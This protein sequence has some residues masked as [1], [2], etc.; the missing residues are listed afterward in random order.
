MALGRHQSA[1]HEAGDDADRAPQLNNGELGV[2]IL[3]DCVTLTSLVMIEE[4]AIL[5]ANSGATDGE[6]AALNFHYIAAECNHV[7]EQPTIG[8]KQHLHSRLAQTLKCFVVVAQIH[9]GN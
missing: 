5:S 8:N 4:E 6:F 3:P 2:K 1:I 9:C 7:C